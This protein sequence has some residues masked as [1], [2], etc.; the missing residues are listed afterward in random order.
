M[1]KSGKQNVNRAPRAENRRAYHDYAIV[2]KLECGIALLGTEVK[3]L[4]EGRA[5]LAGSFAR[6]EPSGE[7][8]AYNVEI[9]AYSN[10][11]SERQH[12]PKRPRKLLAKRRQISELGTRTGVG[13]STTLIPLAIYFNDRGIAKMELGVA[14]GKTHVD[15][16]QTI[17]KKETDRAIQRA[18]TRKR[19]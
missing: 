4:R 15:K 13:A 17:K 10:A 12:E 16:R 11:P 3:A 19:I 2:E 1:A 14:I 9:G 6:V 8:F 5:T 18:M 7:M